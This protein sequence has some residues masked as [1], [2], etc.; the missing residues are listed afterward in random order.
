MHRPLGFG[1][2]LGR[3]ARLAASLAAGLAVVATGP[4]SMASAQDVSPPA[5]GTEVPPGADSGV[6]DTPLGPARWVHQTGDAATLPGAAP[7]AEDSLFVTLE[8]AID[9]EGNQLGRSRWTSADGLR[10]TSQPLSLPVGDSYADFRVEGGVTWLTIDRPGSLWRST[11]QETWEPIAID[12]MIPSGPPALE[13]DVGI[14]TIA[15]ASALTAV[16]LNLDARDPFEGWPHPS[17]VSE[18]EP[19]LFSIAPRGEGRPR[20]LRLE[21]TAT[22]LRVLEDADGSEIAN[23]GRLHARLRH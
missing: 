18:V 12:D 4:L 21:E 16:E 9:D 13:W 3:G 1:G 11:D 8:Q 23:S 22:G 14:G 17:R 20:L 15:S 5:L 10:W 6:I 19:G 2:G 7:F